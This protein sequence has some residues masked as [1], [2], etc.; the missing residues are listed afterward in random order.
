MPFI[1]TLPQNHIKNYLSTLKKSAILFTVF[2]SSSTYALA[3]KVVND[4]LVGTWQCN[5]EFYQAGIR[6]LLRS[7]DTYTIQGKIT[8]KG[9]VSILFNPKLPQV[10]YTSKVS[11]LWQYDQPRLKGKMTDLTLINTS[12]PEL[13]ILFNPTAMLPKPLSGEFII[14]SLNNKNMALASTGGEVD[15]HCTR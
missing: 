13:D 10:T 7:T 3:S 1:I 15:Y 5:A 11:G 8:S 12:H 6:V 2:F 9:S 4:Y 14:K